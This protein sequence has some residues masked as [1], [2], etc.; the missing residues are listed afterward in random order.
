[1]LQNMRDPQDVAQC[2]V[3]GTM[4]WFEDC[5]WHCKPFNVF[6][7]SNVGSPNLREVFNTY[8]LGAGGLMGATGGPCE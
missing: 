2:S 1:M 3:A 7:I 6:I 4:E 5:V 8:L